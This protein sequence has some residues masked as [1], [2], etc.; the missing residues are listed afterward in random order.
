MNKNTC[1]PALLNAKLFIEKNY[2]K[3]L[4]VA[5]IAASIEISQSLLF[6]LFKESEGCTPIEY[7]RKIRI[8]NAKL[9]LS[10]EA[11]I[12]IKDIGVECGFSDTSYFVKVFKSETEITPKKFRDL[13]KI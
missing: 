8:E 5:E 4:S 7:L 2:K 6:K 13:Y 3:D 9:L 10:N 1:P 12:S 11:D